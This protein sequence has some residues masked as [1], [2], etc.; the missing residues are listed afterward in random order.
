MLLVIPVPRRGNIYFE[1]KVA[2]LLTGIR[3]LQT[4]LCP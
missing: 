4:C 1:G 3:D 2:V